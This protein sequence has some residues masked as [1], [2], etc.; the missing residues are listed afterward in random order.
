MPAPEDVI[1]VLVASAALDEIAFFEH[2]AGNTRWEVLQVHSLAEVA[3]VFRDHE[4]PVV[5]SAAELPDGTWKG[6]LDAAASRGRDTRV[7]V[8]IGEANDH[9]WSEILDSGGYDVLAKPLDAREAVRVVSLAW[10]Q[11][12]HTRQRARSAPE[13]DG[14][15]G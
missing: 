6:V 2:L 9:L 7:I 1:K 11:W 15:D 14:H 10:R 4:A 13:A 8:L 12:R 3:E 5:I